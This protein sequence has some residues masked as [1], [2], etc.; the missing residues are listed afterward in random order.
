MKNI[1][2]FGSRNLKWKLLLLVMI[3]NLV[4]PQVRSQ[5]FTIDQTLSDEAQRTTIAFDG[6]A[7]VTGCLGADSFFPPGKVADFWGFQ[8]LRDN[9]ATHMGHNTDFLTKAAFNLLYVLT[10]EQRQQLIVL[11]ESQVEMI[12][13]YGYNRFVLMKAFRRLLEGDL[14]PGT[15]GL[16]EEAVKAYSAQL[17]AL[18][19][20]ISYMR[21]KVMGS[22][23]YAFTPSQKSYLDGL[24]I[25]RAHV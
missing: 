9:D 2:E 8:Y 1:S 18:D 6:L 24:K 15:N 21:A 19:G 5:Q 4:Y 12:N 7:F 22:M 16:G 25:G 14:P 20:T 13:Q 10:P 11:A 23:I 3:L 17:Y